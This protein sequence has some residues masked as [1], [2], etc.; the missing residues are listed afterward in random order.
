M[1]IEPLALGAGHPDQPLAL[2]AGAPLPSGPAKQVGVWNYILRWQPA[3][4]SIQLPQVP[5]PGGFHQ[6]H[7]LSRQLDPVPESTLQW[8]QGI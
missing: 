2:G 5:W 4:G 1:R 8:P 6:L 7:N 3:W